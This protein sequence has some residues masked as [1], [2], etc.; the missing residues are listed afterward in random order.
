MRT[1]PHHKHTPEVEE[2]EEIGLQDVIRVIENRIG[3]K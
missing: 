2:S 3:E 1:F